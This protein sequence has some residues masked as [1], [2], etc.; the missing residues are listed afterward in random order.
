MG[1][2]LEGSYMARKGVAKGKPGATYDLNEAK[3]G[4]YHYVY[5]PYA[6][7]VLR[8]KPGDIVVAETHDAF[9]GKIESESDKPSELLNVPFLNPQCGPIAVEGA[10]KGDALAVYI[11]SI[12]PRGTQPIGTTALI[13]EFGGLVATGSTALLNPPLPERVKKM[14][15]TE[16]GIVFNK[17]ITLPYEPFIGT[18]GVSPEIEAVT[19]LQPDYWGGNMDL[20]DVAPGAVVYFPV[21][22][23][24]A[25]LYLGDCHA[26]QGDGEL[27]GVAVEMPSTTTVQ[28]DLIKGWTIAWPR[29][30]NERFIM[31]IGSTR[32]MEDAARIAYRELIRWLVADYGFDE[33]EAYFLLTQAGRVRLGNMVDPKYTLGASLLKSYLT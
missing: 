3:Q 23:K 2:W 32:P 14:E 9:E 27:C 17:K 18:L 10:E 31:T 25:Y 29:L 7:P 33:V 30:E 15:V 28:V 16:Q 19:S 22:H 24:D 4:K 26:T 6:D 5:G 21:H 12:K 11:H 1:S 20:P 8:I 13:T